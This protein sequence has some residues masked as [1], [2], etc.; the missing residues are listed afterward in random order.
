MIE[1]IVVDPKKGKVVSLDTLIWK[2]DQIVLETTDECLIGTIS[3]VLF[4]D[5]LIIIVD[6]D[7]AKS[8][9]V[10]DM[11][12]NFKYKIGNKG[13]GPGE[14]ADM[15]YVCFVS[16]KPWISVWDRQKWK[17][18]FFDV[19]GEY[20]YSDNRPFMIGYYEFLE[21][22]NLAYDVSALK[23][24]GYGNYLGN[25]LM[26]SDNKYNIIYGA[27]H[28]F[29]NYINNFSMNKPL[30]KFGESVYYSPHFTDTIFLITDTAAIAKYAIEITWK[31]M[32][33]LNDQITPDMFDYY[34][35]HYF[36]FGGD[37]IELKDYTYMN[38]L[39]P[40]H[41]NPAIAYFHDTKTTYLVNDVVGNP[42]YA[43]LVTHEPIA[44]YKENSL[45]CAVQ[46]P[47]IMNNKEILYNAYK[48]Y[49]KDIDALFE[50]INEDA[51]PVLFIYHF[52]DR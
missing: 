35:S 8:I 46:S 28:D 51:N 42:F 3:Q 45:V 41:G 18:M 38:F 29:G 47:Y 20:L 32:P 37:F 48:G 25:V 9:L 17:I 19:N 14:Y 33:K 10:F 27:C 50:R 36:R 31:G 21:S 40:F 5:S 12:G 11:E 30:R 7:L 44:R 39:S 24:S 2:S 6:K 22:G 4:A 1:N 13:N 15:N 52:K 49:E 43:F 23:D 16:G 34:R 26:V